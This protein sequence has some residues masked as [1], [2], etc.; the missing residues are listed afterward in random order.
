MST[1]ARWDKLIKPEID[2]ILLNANLTEEQQI[3]LLRAKNKSIVETA[4][5]VGVCIRTL[6]RKIKGIK[7]KIE[8]LEAYD[9]HN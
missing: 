9:D 4:D 2:K 5:N 8:S 1:H 7:R 3:F 6:N